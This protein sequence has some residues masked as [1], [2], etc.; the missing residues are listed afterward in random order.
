MAMTYL[1]AQTAESDGYVPKRVSS[2]AQVTAREPDCFDSHTRRAKEQM[3]VRDLRGF[4]KHAEP[5][6]EEG[7]L[8]DS[9]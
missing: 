4:G 9:T 8:K 6:E 2:A 7:L 5:E 1:L 3:R